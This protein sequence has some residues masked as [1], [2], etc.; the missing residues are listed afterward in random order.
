[1]RMCWYGRHCAQKSTGDF[2]CVFRCVHGWRRW[3]SVYDSIRS[4]ENTD[5]KLKNKKTNPNE[6]LRLIYVHTAA[7]S[8]L[9]V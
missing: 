4:Y 2:M 5:T 8:Q 6:V 1:M 9:L 3:S 7:D